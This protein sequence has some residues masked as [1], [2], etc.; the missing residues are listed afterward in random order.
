MPPKGK[1]A[2]GVLDDLKNWVKARPWPEPSPRSRRRPRRHAQGVRREPFVSARL[3]PEMPRTSVDWFVLKGLDEAGLKPSKPA[4]R[5]TLIRRWS[6][7]LIGLPPTPEEVRAYEADTSPDAD[8]K[9]ATASKF[10]SPHYGEA[11]GGVTGSTLRY[12]TK[13]YA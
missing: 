2:D 1:L 12:A 6:Y 7:T 9:V 5:R 11:A 13:G 4:D 10:A 3:R 8:R